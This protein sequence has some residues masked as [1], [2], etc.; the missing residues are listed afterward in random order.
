MFTTIKPFIDAVKQGL[1]TEAEIDVTLKRL[2][3]AR[4]RLGMFD[5]P[6]H[7]SVCQHAGVGDR[8]RAAPRPGAQDRA[9]I[10]GAAEE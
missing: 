10:D 6:R 5:P 7:G 9:R 1:L 3:T 8:Q 2:F 4:M